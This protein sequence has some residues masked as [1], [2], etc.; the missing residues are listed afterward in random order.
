MVVGML[1]QDA[2]PIRQQILAFSPIP[3]TA[4]LA[5]NR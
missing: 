1:G 5:R 2:Q 4:P 3:K